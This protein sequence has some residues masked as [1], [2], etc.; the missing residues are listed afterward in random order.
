[1]NWVRKIA[2]LL[3]YACVATVIAEAVLALTIV[4][5]LK[6]NRERTVQMLAIAYG[7]DLFAMR[8]EVAA[9]QEKE[10][11]SAEQ[12]SF[13]QILEARALKT[14]DIEFREQA[15]QNGLEQLR[16]AQRK[17]ADEYKRCA[18]LK[19]SFDAALKALDEGAEA[20]GADAVRRILETIKPKQAKELIVQMLADKKLDQVVATLGAMS[21]AKRAKIIGEFKTPEETVKIGEVL[22]RIREGTPTA[23]MAEETRTQLQKSNKNF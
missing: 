8:E 2:S 9:A 20:S 21:D 15:L 3:M 14:R 7:M 19:D 4:P 1:M 11:I 13:D 6:L 10:R 5:R 23:Q 16:V 18:Q 12:A 17:A 22:R